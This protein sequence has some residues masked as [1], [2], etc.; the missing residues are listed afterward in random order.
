MQSVLL[1]IIPS[2]NNWNCCLKQGGETVYY[3]YNWTWQWETDFD[4]EETNEWK[5][6]HKTQGVE[7]LTSFEGIE[8]IIII[9]ITE[10]DDASSK[11]A[12]KVSIF[13]CVGKSCFRPGMNKTQ[14]QESS[15]CTT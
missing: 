10:E 4:K 9:I 13:F 1:N 12:W 11:L 5:S 2:A 6:Q 14:G 3:Y 8:C 15:L 7:K